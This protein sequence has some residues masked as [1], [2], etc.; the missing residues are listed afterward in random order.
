MHGFV[1]AIQQK[2]EI[3]LA[4]ARDLHDGAQRSYVGNSHARNLF[5]ALKALAAM[6]FSRRLSLRICSRSK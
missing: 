5:S 6:R 2:V 4:F 1:A 3:E